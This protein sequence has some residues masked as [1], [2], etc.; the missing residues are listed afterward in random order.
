MKNFNDFNFYTLSDEWLVN[1]I[2][3]KLSPEETFQRKGFTKEQLLFYYREMEKSGT[4][5]FLGS[6]SAGFCYR[7]YY[8]NIHVVE[9][10][11]IGNVSYLRTFTKLATDFM[12]TKNNIEKITVYTPYKN[13]GKIMV[14]FGY[15][16]EGTITNTYLKNDELLD[17]DIFGLNKKDYICNI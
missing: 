4:T 10:H 13:I 16:Y 12:F 14:R 15:N 3:D 11:L 8:P 5:E 6:P 2:L 1:L 9:P 7:L 17:L